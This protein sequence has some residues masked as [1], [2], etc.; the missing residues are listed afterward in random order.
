MSEPVEPVEPW[1][2]DDVPEYKL[3]VAENGEGED[4]V[5][6]YRTHIVG[7]RGKLM[8]AA[9]VDTDTAT[10]VGTASTSLAAELGGTS[11]TRALATGKWVCT[12]DHV[13]ALEKPA[14][15]ARREQTWEYYSTWAPIPE[16][17]EWDT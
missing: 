7:R 5:M 4:R 9:E 11:I 12:T 13:R 10:D 17:W 8:T 1:T 2:W 6:E 15:F 16:S 14:A 3:I